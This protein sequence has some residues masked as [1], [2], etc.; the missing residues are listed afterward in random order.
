MKLRSKIM[1]GMLCFLLLSLTL[2]CALI[3][4]I[5][6][7]NMLNSTTNYTKTELEK[8]VSN[9]YANIT[10]IEKNDS[11]LTAYS[12]L[13]YYFFRQ[14]QFSDAYTE[15]VLQENENMIY[16][17]SGLNI[18]NILKLESDNN[19]DIKSRIVHLENYD[20]C[21]TGTNIII[22][23]KTYEIGIVRNITE[24][25]TR[26]YQMIYV[27]VG[28]GLIISFMAGVCIII[29]L[30][31]S[32]EP[33]EQL[34]EEADAISA[35]E[36]DRQ[37][38]VSG[39]DELASLSHSFNLMA[40]AVEEHIAEV[41]ETSEARNR[42]IHALSHEMRTPVT[43]I[44][45]YSYSLRSMKLS[46]EQ[47]E[48]ALEFIDLEAKRLESLSGKLTILVGLNSDSIE[49]KEI[50]MSDLKKY[51]QR[52][53]A[54]RK[55]ITLQ[56]EEGKIIGDMDLLIMLI[57][58]LCDNAVKADATQIHI[59]VAVDGIW[60]KDNGKGISEDEKKRIFEAFYQGDSSRNQDGFGLGL[61]LCQKIA[62][63]HHTKL[64]VK[65]DVGKGS[66][67]YLYNSFT[68]L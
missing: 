56:V 31:K 58:N 38:K 9:F 55:D 45:G 22:G 25:F 52:I 13:K 54:T 8:L 63:L 5:S 4:S 29:F 12:K 59:K 19:Q 64:C 3:I 67:F 33:L 26:I 16:N 37:I 62:Q 44:C 14:T 50:N 39:K 35:G 48:E 27:C 1:A 60:V 65:S 24:L 41:L 10:D 61:A 30:K 28:I 17:N 15:Y 43:A 51:L 32:F 53:F 2:C 47:K 18:A 46:E 23:E 68:T 34:K 7:E 6:K 49:M 42:L 20:Y 36:Y 40:R 57:T 66:T 11:R 21:V